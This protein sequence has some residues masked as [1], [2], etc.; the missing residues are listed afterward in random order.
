MPEP[1]EAEVFRSVLDK[2]ALGVYM[3]NR[4]FQVLFWNE[5]AEAITPNEANA[6]LPDLM[7]YRLFIVCY[8]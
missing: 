4:A 2:L 1:L 5:G 8:P 3:V 7:K 6:T